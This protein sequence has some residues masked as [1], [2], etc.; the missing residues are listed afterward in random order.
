MII[1]LSADD[2]REK[3]GSKSE[4]VDDKVLFFADYY[5]HN[6]ECAI[7]EYPKYAKRVGEERKRRY[8]EL[9]QHRGPF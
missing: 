6:L 3:Y 9:M 4:G 1:G 5:G 8:E 2:L 7:S